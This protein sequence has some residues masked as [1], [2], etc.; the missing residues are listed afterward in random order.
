MNTDSFSKLAFTWKMAGNFTSFFNLLANAKKFKHKRK[1]GS[2]DLNNTNYETYLVNQTNGKFQI[3][4]R[5]YRGDVSIFN[6]IFWKKSYFIPNDYVQKPKVI[7][8]LG[9]HIGFASIFYTLNYPEAKIYSIE[10]SKQNVQLLE[11]N[12]KS[13]PNI[14]PLN[15]A[16]YTE[17]GYI[18]FDESGLSYNNKISDKGEQIEAISVN[19]LLELYGIQKI[20]LIKIDI[21]GSEKDILQKNTEWLEKTDVIIIELHKPYT[22]KDLEKDLAPYNFRV[23][24]PS[25]ENQLKNIVAIKDLT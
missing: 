5:T 1:N 23:I 11:F 9:A 4:M 25:Q 20:D 3:K 6:E 15:K 19:S 18:S 2:I 21:E 24:L 16:V 7:I 22:E 17:D 14:T 10:A 13:F 12:T 8:D